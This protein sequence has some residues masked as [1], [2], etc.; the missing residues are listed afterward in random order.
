MSRFLKKL[1]R[2]FENIYIHNMTTLVMILKKDPFLVMKSGEK[3]Y[4]YR[5]N[6]KYWRSRL[7]KKDGTLKEFAY[8]E[9]SNGYQKDRPQFK[10]EFLGFDIVQ[11][12]CETY[13]TGFKV[14]YPEKEEGYI[15]IKLGEIC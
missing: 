8:V 12:V 10:C 5:E 14:N 1:I 13:S 7:Y 15:R 11:E 6:T 9:F 4:E 3:K 2:A